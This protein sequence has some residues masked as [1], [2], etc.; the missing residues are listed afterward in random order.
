MPDGES[1]VGHYSVR[2]MGDTLEQA[3]AVVFRRDGADVQVLLVRARRSPNDW[4]FPKGHIE[5]GESPGEAALRE[6]AEEAGVAGHAVT[7]L[8]PA[9]TFPSG[10]DQIRVQYYLIEFSG[11]VPAKERR[12]KIWLPAPEALTTLTHPAA[13]KLLEGALN[14]LRGE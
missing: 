13:R 1:S 14:H 3:G 6:A 7:A 9:L 12:D 5:D 2:Y 4:I 8:W 10:D 11:E